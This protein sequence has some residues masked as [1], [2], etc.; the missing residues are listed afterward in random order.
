[1]NAELVVLHA[2]EGDARYLVDGTVHALSAGVLLWAQAGRAHV[3]LDD[4]P[5]FDMR[6]MLISQH[7]LPHTAEG[8]WPH[9]QI[10]SDAPL[11]PHR[12]PPSVTAELEQIAQSVEAL[13]DPDSQR[14]GLQ[15]WLM[16][17]W[18]HWHAAP[19]RQGRA[20]HPAVTRAT[21]ALRD[22][23][24]LSL[25][26]VAKH[27]GLSQGRLSRL[28]AAQTG[29]SLSAF[30]TECRLDL[31]EALY[32]EGSATWLAAAF[33]AG[34]GSYTQFYRAYVARHGTGPRGK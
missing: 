24:L 7:I 22:R 2:L 23:P 21:W 30:R 18:H 31:T 20:V 19:T 15:Y 8:A 34:F 14:A 5:D 32:A 4:T 28:F 1:M 13:T 6:V 11:P 25:E 12:L 26:D 10:G 29:R 17:A 27:T 3:L 16:R 9:V 33:E